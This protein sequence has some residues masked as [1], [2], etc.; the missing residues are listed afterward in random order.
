[1]S[2]LSRRE[3]QGGGEFPIELNK[4]QHE[5]GGERKPQKKPAII[6]RARKKNYN[7]LHGQVN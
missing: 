6:K 7:T 1:M 2:G 3:K 4:K 5:G